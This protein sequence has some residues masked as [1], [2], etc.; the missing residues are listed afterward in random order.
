MKSF[1]AFLRLTIC[2]LLLS[3]STTAIANPIDT[4]NGSKEQSHVL[5]AGNSRSVL[6]NSTPVH[7][8]SKRAPPTPLGPDWQCVFDQYYQSFNH[9]P[10]ASRALSALYLYALDQLNNPSNANLRIPELSIKVGAFELLFRTQKP[11]SWV[12]M[13]MVKAFV[14]MM[15]RRTQRGLAIKY[16]GAAHGPDGAV[17]EILIYMIEPIATG[18]LDSAM[19]MYGS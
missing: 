17:V 12:P 15:L 9:I 18:L 10:S 5:I 14:V 13:D 1:A 11:G 2:S 4:K 7:S 19:D 3:I 16:A 6:P 8:L